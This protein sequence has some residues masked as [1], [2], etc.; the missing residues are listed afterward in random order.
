[1]RRAAAALAIVPVVL[2]ALLGAPALALANR[3]AEGSPGDQAP[4][5]PAAR[6]AAGASRPFDPASDDWQGLS[7]LVRMARDDLG[8]SRVIV[9]PALDLSQLEREDALLLVHPERDLDADEL[10]AFMHAGGR[11][12]LLDDYGTGDELLA[13]FGIR[14]VPLPD[15]PAEMLRGNPSLPIA[16]AAGPHEVVR[17]LS[18]VVIN[19]GTGLDQP[20]LSPLL[21]VHGQGEPDVLVAM[22][23][24]VGRGGL[25][26][27]GDASV[28]IN[29]M[30]RYPANRALAAS[31]VRYATRDDAWGPR[32]GKL[33]VLV[34]D[35]E[36]V[37]A[38]GAGTSAGGAYDEARRAALGALETLRREGMPPMAAYL[39]ALVVGL[40]VVVWTSARAGKTHRATTPCFVRPVPMAAHGGVAGRAAALTAPNA[41][42]ALAL[43]EL[44]SALEEELATRLGL[45]RT[46]PH[47]E[48]VSRLR[49]ANLVDAA[50]AHDLSRL[51]AML[52]RMETRLATRRRGA[53]ER[54]R[55][56]DVLA[57]AAR[58]R[59]VLANVAAAPA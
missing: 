41:P 5:A 17:G 50:V 16:E 57:V 25:V 53:V 4:A 12:V 30:M 49:A 35:F 7:E 39:A 14:R 31:L 42:R 24:A 51:L 20:A 55:D 58:V 9:A 19:H 56:A 40:G 15:R 33:Y 28:A 44:K 59:E 22:T 21:V 13:R 46:P 34:G 43:L 37:G 1:M 32:R 3:A 8:A 47:E 11:I 48:L 52:A 10:A 54:V 38:F 18:H 45:D 2:L 27:V 6:R 26:A 36:T 23:G 29:E